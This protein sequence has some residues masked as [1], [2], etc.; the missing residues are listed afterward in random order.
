MPIQQHQLH[1]SVGIG[2]RRHYSDIFLSVNS[3]QSVSWIEVI[4]ENYMTW[5]NHKVPNSSLEMLLALRQ[6]YDVYLHGVSLS[7]G[8]CDP[9]DKDY[10]LSLKN[11]I[12]TVKPKI[13]SDHLSWSTLDSHNT[14][15]LLPLVYNK[16]SLLNIK[17][18]IDQVQNLLQ[19]TILIENPSTYLE[20]R[21]SN[22]EETDFINEICSQSGCGLLLDINNVFVNSQNHG[23]NAQ[24]YLTK[25]QSH[26]VQQ[27]HLAG[28]TQEDDLIVDTHDHDVS[29]SVWHLFSWYT[30]KFGIFP[31]MIERD[32]HFPD[33]SELEKEVL[34]IAKI[35]EEYEFKQQ[36]HHSVL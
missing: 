29:S 12:D 27:I 24:D 9:I 34:M 28:H 32:D 7:I 18:K 25:I 15:D 3:P 31:T 17:N 4:S 5:K 21:D 30:Q 36:K 10:I 16:E 19:R 11:L 6:Q 26:N 20:F 1:H 22:I 33:W 2:F 13:V 35:Q 23:F 8:S 14:H